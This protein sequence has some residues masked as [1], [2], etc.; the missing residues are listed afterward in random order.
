LLGNYSP[1]D[2]LEVRLIV[3]PADPADK[4]ASRAEAVRI[5][6]EILDGS[7][8]ADAAL[9]YS[10]GPGADNGG[11]TGEGLVVGQLHPTLK[12]AVDRLEPGTPSAP[13]DMGNAFVI[14]TSVPKEAVKSS[15]RGSA[16][17]ALADF[18]PQA[19]DNA[20]RQ[21][22]RY[23]MQQRYVEWLKDLKSKAIVRISL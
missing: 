3:L 9:M 20:R 23:K 16:S 14:L 18:P 6:Q 8:F 1:N 21:L 10:R 7:S 11:D 19:V 15:G 13:V 5:R 12:A 22:E 17:S 2:H 4:E